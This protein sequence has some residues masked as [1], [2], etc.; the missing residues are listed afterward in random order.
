MKNK[1][2]IK[3][4]YEMVL[5]LSSVQSENWKCEEEEKNV[6]C[7]RGSIFNA[8][9]DKLLKIE[10]SEMEIQEKKKKEGL[11]TTIIVVDQ[12]IHLGFN[13]QNEIFHILK[14]YKWNYN[15]V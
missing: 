8:C 10:C 11:W 14:K 15:L 3:M 5:I 13:P 9:Y 12:T 6:H 1:Q 7:P 2:I 4:R